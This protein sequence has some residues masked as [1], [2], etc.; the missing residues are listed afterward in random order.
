MLRLLLR[1]YLRHGARLTA[2]R[3]RREIGL[4]YDDSD[5]PRYTA[6][7]LDD[8]FYR[9]ARLLRKRRLT[10]AAGVLEEERARAKRKYASR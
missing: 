5:I 1:L 2:R 3:M 8:F 4:A 7:A 9:A 6:A 10:G